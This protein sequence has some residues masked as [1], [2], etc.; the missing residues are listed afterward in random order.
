MHLVLA[1]AAALAISN[2]APLY[3]TIT[4]TVGGPGGRDFT[5]QCPA[6][7]AAIGF[8]ARTGAW[9]D[10][11]ALI[12]VSSGK[13]GR[14]LSAWNGGNSGSPQEVYCPTN[15]FVTD[16]AMTFTRGKGLEREYLNTIGI[17]CGSE[18]PDYACISTDDG[19]KE[20]FFTPTN[21]LGTGFGYNVKA[22]RLSCPADEVVL[23]LL[24]RAGKYVDAVGLICGPNPFRASQFLNDSV[25]KHSP[26]PELPNSTKIDENP[27]VQAAQPS[28]TG[29]S[30]DASKISKGPAT[31][32]PK[33]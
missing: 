9:V 2:H 19:C 13:G 21:I 15:S 5:V 8:Q 31:S 23:G 32:K 27:S 18:R 11:L 4:E 1:L 25:A 7:S 20:R 22:D 6:G 28:A 26:P 16:V 14:T 17:G 33:D 30:T 24:G 29:V 3:A 12:C 10:G